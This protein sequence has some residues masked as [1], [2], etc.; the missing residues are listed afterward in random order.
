[1]NKSIRICALIVSIGAATT[2]AAANHA[3]QLAYSL[4]TARALRAPYT[5]KTTPSAAPA[6]QQRSLPSIQEQPSRIQRSA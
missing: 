1:M 2:A 3:K 6:P 4:P 5:P